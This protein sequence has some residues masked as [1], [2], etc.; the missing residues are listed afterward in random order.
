VRPLPS[1]AAT[2]S[3]LIYAQEILGYGHIV[4]VFWTLCYEIQFYLLLI[5]LLVIWKKARAVMPPRAWRTAGILVLAGLFAI[6]LVLRY[7]GRHLPIHGIALERW[8]QFFLGALTYWVLSKRIGVSYLVVAYASIVAALVAYRADAA[9]LLPVVVSAGLLV[10]GRRGLLDSV[11][12]SRPLQFMGRISYS[13]YLIH[14][15]I[16]WRWIS[17]LERAMGPRFGLVW[18]WAA[19]ASACAITIGASAVMWRLIESPTMRLSK[20]IRLPSRSS[21]PDQA[22]PKP[23]G[24][25]GL[26]PAYPADGL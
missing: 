23:A 24:A 26:S 2:F 11:F 18:A 3:H 22:T 9:Q 8:F 15:P 10:L 21:E 25:A 7:S 4:P 13:F 20:R 16:G 17:L 6:S 12:A 5:T 19:F 1:L 14:S